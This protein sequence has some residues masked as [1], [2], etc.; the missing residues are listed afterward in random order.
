MKLERLKKWIEDVSN[1]E[2]VNTLMEMNNCYHQQHPLCTITKNGLTNIMATTEKKYTNGNEKEQKEGIFIE[3][4]TGPKSEDI[5]EMHIVNYC[6]GLR[7]GFYKVYTASP[8]NG[9]NDF[10]QFHSIGR[11]RN[12]KKVGFSWKWL[13]GNGYFIDVDEE[14]DQDSLR[15]GYFLYPNL[16]CG[17]HGKQL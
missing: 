4:A 2:N 3:Y 16:S 17:I 14:E 1:V 8:Y 11:F 10:T 15:D 9:N 5:T 7:H 13:E 6:N 12:G